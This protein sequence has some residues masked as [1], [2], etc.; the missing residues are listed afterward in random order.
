MAVLVDSNIIDVNSTWCVLQLARVWELPRSRRE[1][2]LGCR[3]PRLTPA[4]AALLLRL[5][6]SAVSARAALALLYWMVDPSCCVSFCA[7][8][9]CSL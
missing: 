6:P 4:P 8:Y 5:P 7:G 2:S 3:L 1:S 9:G